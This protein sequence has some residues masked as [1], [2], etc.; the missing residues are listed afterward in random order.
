M[1]PRRAGYR[2]SE[3]RRTAGAGTALHMPPSGGGGVDTQHLV[4]QQGVLRCRGTALHTAA[5]AG[6]YG[7]VRLLLAHGADLNAKNDD[8]FVRNRRQPSRE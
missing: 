8:G 2:E 7:I 4:L 3:T 6:R 1:D 5:W